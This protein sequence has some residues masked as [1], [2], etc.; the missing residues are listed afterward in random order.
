[1]VLEETHKPRPCLDDLARAA[2]GGHNLAAYLVTIL[3]YRYIGDA[4]ENDTTRRY[5]RWIEGE[6]ELRVVI[7]GG[8]SGPMSRWLM[9]CHHEVAT[10]V[11][12]E[13]RWA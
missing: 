12:R 3:L 8:G 13:M 10:E 2:D 4:R 9:L 7:A 1:M 5:M 6:E 11:I